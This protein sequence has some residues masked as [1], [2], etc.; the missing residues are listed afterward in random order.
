MLFGREGSI[1]LLDGLLSSC[2]QGV[3]NAL[4]VIGP[5][6][7]GKSSLLDYVTT[8]VR[9]RPRS[10]WQVISTKAFE[11]ESSISYAGLSQILSHPLSM[12]S[13]LSPSQAAAVNA[14][15][16]SG[17]PTG[18][19]VFPVYL[20]VL[21]LLT[22][23]AAKGPLL[24]LVDDAHWLDVASRDALTFA[25]RRLIRDPIL[26]VV[27]AR[28]GPALGPPWTDFRQHELSGLDAAPARA[29]LAEHGHRLDE[30]LLP[31]LME[32]TGGN[33]LALL[34]LPSFVS[35][36][37]L[38]SNSKWSKPAPIG[39]TL[40]VAYGRSFLQMS[41]EAQEAALIV[42][43]LDEAELQVAA[44]ALRFAGLPVE[45]LEPGMDAGLIERTEVGIRMRHP[46]MRSAI[47]QLAKPSA[48]RLAHL[49]AADG[50]LSSS[51]LRSR[52][53]R[54]WHL[55]DAALDVDETTAQLLESLAEEAAGQTGYASARLTLERAAELS[56]TARGRSRRLLTAAHMAFAGGESQ[57]CRALI[58]RVL[59][60]P[61][62]AS[63]DA[64]AIDHLQDRLTTWS[65]D[66]ISAAKRMRVQ[67]ERLAPLHPV[68]S[69]QLSVDAA[70]AAAL[71]GDMRLAS[72]IAE[73]V[74]QVTKAAGEEAQPIGDLL[75]GS[76]QA[77]RGD[78]TEAML[79]LDRCRGGLVN[80]APSADLVQQLVYLATA[81]HFVDG[82]APATELFHQATHLARQRGA[83]G[84]LPFALAHLASTEYRVGRWDAAIANASEAL[85]LAADS[86][87]PADRPIAHVMLGMIKAPRGDPA[88]LEH[89]KTAMKEASALGITFV[90]AQALSVL[91]L[92][93]LSAGRPAQAVPHLEECAKI[94]TGLDIRELGYLQWSAE[95]I[96]AQARSGHLELAK[97]TLVFMESSASQ[98]TTPLNRA[99]LARCRGIAAADDS[100][101]VHFENSL[102]LHRQECERPFEL[103]RSELCFGERLR[104]QRRRRE[105]RT[106]LS[107]AWDIFT[108]LGADP[109]SRRC[110]QE[111]QA[112]G[113]VGP[114]VISHRADLL[115]PQELGVARAVAS[116]ATNREAADA[117]FVSLKTVEFHLS[118]I[119]RR[120]GLR[121]RSELARLL[122]AEGLSPNE[123][124]EVR[125]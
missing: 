90:V 36:Q 55:A 43:V 63:A 58:D 3:G 24:V 114:G 25:A 87:R 1:E 26:L 46:L 104:R 23:T 45:A 57:R 105:A 102:Q 30:S 50:L 100:W 78:G 80:A 83:L 59:E 10:G 67:A 6:G 17:P 18:D 48:R 68:L 113:W 7:I 110:G 117:L 64:D 121:S 123:R 81:Y 115:T 88:A 60:G 108:Q 95:L 125:S 84:P 13:E 66:P 44:R 85:S 75:V 98:G 21:N 39:R 77:M 42:S 14:A 49:A 107:A 27:A 22:L 35:P 72:E 111:L 53:R 86:G 93:E 112:T 109:W 118:A 5:A 2:E 96:E 62:N 4:A 91:G 103:A 82:F 11:G 70:A 65:G 106:H 54:I 76:V 12:L 119:Y 122:E 52:E 89:A 29:L 37:D 74:A 32:L 101:E 120:L 20:G 61:G 51:R 47:V 71:A 79:L 28:N 116:G 8:Q 94:A 56:E 92:V 33:P 124:N 73:F 19:G 9:E 31:R 41:H 40:E 34:D 38:S 97:P 99:V 69:I 15:L 16:A